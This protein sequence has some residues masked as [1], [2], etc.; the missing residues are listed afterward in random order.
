MMATRRQILAALPVVPALGLIAARPAAAFFGPDVREV[1]VG[2]SSSGVLD[3]K[4]SRSLRIQTQQVGIKT[5]RWVDR[6]GRTDPTM[7]SLTQNLYEN[8]YNWQTSVQ[9]STDIWRITAEDLKEPTLM[10]LRVRGIDSRPLAALFIGVDSASSL[11]PEKGVEVPPSEDSDTECLALFRFDPAI[12]HFV[13]VQSRID[14]RV[15]YRIVV[16]PASR[17]RR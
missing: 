15:A 5:T 8:K 17:F 4:T 9:R 11:D 13:A 3:I 12:K 6:N 10:V 7:G 1:E 14:E 2:S 16:L